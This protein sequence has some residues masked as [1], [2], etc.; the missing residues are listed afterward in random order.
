MKKK[1][2]AFAIVEYKDAHEFPIEGITMMH[3]LGLVSA[4]FAIRKTAETV[5]QDSK[6]WRKRNGKLPVNNAKIVPCVITYEI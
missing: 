5:M 1:V 6:I 3:S 2:Q 4:V